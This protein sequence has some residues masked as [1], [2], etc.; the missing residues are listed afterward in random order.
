MKKLVEKR[1]V[2]KALLESMLATI[3]QEERAFTEDETKKFD[4]TEANVSIEQSR[5]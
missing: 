4:E 1:A 2:L 5:C 3:K